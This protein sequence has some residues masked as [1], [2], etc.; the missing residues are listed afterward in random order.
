MLLP[1]IRRFDICY[2]FVV[3]SIVCTICWCSEIFLNGLHLL[4]CKEVC[5]C[6]KMM[7]NGNLLEAMIVK[8]WPLR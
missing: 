7:F 5:V 4:A 3:V 2:F 1:S 8:S 6:E